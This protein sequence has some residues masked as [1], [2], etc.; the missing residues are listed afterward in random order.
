V[1]TLAARRKTPSTS[2]ATQRARPRPLG[3]GTISVLITLAHAASTSRPPISATTERAYSGTTIGLV[4]MSRLPRLVARY[5]TSP[6]S[7]AKG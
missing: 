2:W 6:A 1:V 7:V 5:P 3:R 4:I